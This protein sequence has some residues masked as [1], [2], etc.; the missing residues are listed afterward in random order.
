MSLS[1]FNIFTS[2]GLTTKKQSESKRLLHYHN[3]PTPLS[4]CHKL[5]IVS[6][7]LKGQSSA[8]LSKK[9]LVNQPPISRSVSSH[10]KISWKPPL[11]RIT[12][13]W[14]KTRRVTG[15]DLQRASSGRRANLPPKI[16]CPTRSLQVPARPLKATTAMLPHVTTK[17]RNQRSV[18]S[19]SM[20]TR[21]RIAPTRANRIRSRARSSRV[22]WI[23]P[24]PQNFYSP[25][26][27]PCAWRYI[28][29]CLLLPLTKKNLPWLDSWQVSTC[30]CRVPTRLWT[31]V[32][33]NSKKVPMI[34][35]NWWGYWLLSPWHVP[36]KLFCRRW[37]RWWTLQ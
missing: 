11:W 16:N 14:Q 2:R 20:G 29:G 24:W 27:T 25:Q 22:V 5:L 18:M 34:K 15:Q 21:M 19:H 17:R 8:D 1:Q 6:D 7:L 35:R 10:L 23:P 9:Q 33:A 31:E 26:C 4:E 12:N 32:Y 3:Y 30:S 13:L 28:P 37:Q 36:K